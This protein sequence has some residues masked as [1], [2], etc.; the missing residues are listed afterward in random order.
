MKVFVSISAL[1]FSILAHHVY[2]DDYLSEWDI[3]LSNPMAENITDAGLETCAENVTNHGEF[4]SCVAHLVK[5]LVSAGDLNQTEAQEI[6]TAAAQSDVGKGD[7]E[8]G[9]GGDG[10]STYTPNATMIPMTMPPV[11]LPSASEFL[12]E[13]GIVLSSKSAAAFDDCQASATSWGEFN[14]CAQH[15]ANSIKK[16]S[17]KE[18][19]NIKHAI[20]AY[21]PT[22]L[23]ILSEG[24]D[25][26]DGGDGSSNS[27][28]APTNIT[29]TMAPSTAAPLAPLGQY[30]EDQTGI[31]LPAQ[32]VKALNSC[33][34]N[35]KNW[36]KIN[37]C[38][39]KVLNSMK[40][41]LKGSA[42]KE[43]KSLN[44]ALQSYKKQL[45]Q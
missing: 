5:E 13:E 43:E 32:T 40:K 21:K 2:S 33:S 29:A 9:D 38:A 42:K 26:N 39:H 25:N 30:M 7:G 12:T 37:S 6:Q 4:V 36:G 10:N 14:S 19:K 1:L 8:G 22:F 11:S 17:K 27:T 35:A 28:M 34:E 44:K 45:S 24:E 16:A 20:S 15:V 23:Q 3:T 31:T 41:S 18:T